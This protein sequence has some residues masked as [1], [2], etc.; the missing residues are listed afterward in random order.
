MHYLLR[1][2][3]MPRGIEHEP[4]KIY[5]RET[6]K[7]ETRMRDLIIKRIED[8]RVAEKG[9]SKDTTR[10]K[11][12]FIGQIHIS[13]TGKSDFERLADEDLLDVYNSIYL[14]YIGNPNLPV[15][16]PLFC[17]LC[18]K[19]VTHSGIECSK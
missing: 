1:R 16:R 2:Y 18:E 11:N 8:L 14:R 3:T 12:T 7:M 17:I 15:V 19:G 10:W 9:F 6:M 4:K 13:L 5:N